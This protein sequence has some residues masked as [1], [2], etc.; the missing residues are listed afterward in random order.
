MN[1]EIEFDASS[2]A[3][4]IEALSPA[5]LQSILS[6]M[7][8]DSTYMPFDIVFRNAAPSPSA[9][10]TDAIMIGIGLS[11]QKHGT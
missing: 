11:A 4:Q 7:E 6:K 8:N 5:V 1:I 9:G 2:L 10:P 3:K